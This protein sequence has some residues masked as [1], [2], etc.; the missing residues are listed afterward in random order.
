[1]INS[2]TTPIVEMWTSLPILAHWRGMA[3]LETRWW[4]LWLVALISIAACLQTKLAQVILLRSTWRS[5]LVAIWAEAAPLIRAI[6][7]ASIWTET[8]TPIRAGSATL[9]V[10]TTAAICA[11]SVPVALR[12][13][14]LAAS[15]GVSAAVVPVIEGAAIV[16]AWAHIVVTLASA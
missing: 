11:S 16:R 5:A 9:V 3:L 4:V 15:V 6:P 7:S 10:A 14:F 12:S 8:L 1:M 13:L 2:V